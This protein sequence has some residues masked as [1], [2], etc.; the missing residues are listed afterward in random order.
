MPSK[1]AP[2]GTAIVRSVTAPPPSAR[3]AAAPP[4]GRNRPRG[5]APRPPQQVVVASAA[6]QRCA[7]RQVVDLEDR[8]GVIAQAPRRPKSK[9]TREADSAGSSACTAACRRRRRPA[10]GGLGT[11]TPPR[12]A[13]G[14]AGAAPPPRRAD[15]T[16]RARAPAPRS[17]V[18]PARGGCAR[19]L[20]L[21]RIGVEERGIQRR[22][23]QPHAVVVQPGR[24]QRRAEHAQGLR[25]A[26]RR[27][28]AHNQLPPPEKELAGLAALGAHAAIGVSEIGEAQGAARRCR[29]GSRPRARSAPSCPCAAQAAR[30]ARRTGGRRAGRP[31]GPARP[32][33]P[34][35]ACRSRR[36]RARRTP[37]APPR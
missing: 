10:L 36:S 24:V 4:S 21:H 23:S 28:K 34:A 18:W 7:E 5:R 19:A 30:P 35:R 17:R 13:A 1:S 29:S 14:R 16:G 27:R 11:S 20:A 26:L 6:A 22:V 33:T 31:R 25:G 8:A 2:R 12:A 9:I 3:C 15:R 32:R 37:S